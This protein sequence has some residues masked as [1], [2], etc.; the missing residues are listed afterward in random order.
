MRRMLDIYAGLGGASSAFVNDPSWEV[1]RLE[2]NPLITDPNSE[3]HVPGTTHADV[4]EWDYRQYPPGYFDLIWASPPCREFSDALAAPARLARIEG[5]EFYPDTSLL[6][7]AKEIIDY[8]QPRD[9]IIENVRGARKIFSEILDSQP[10]Q[11][12]GSFF[13][14]GYFPRLHLDIDWRHA[15]HHNDKSSNHPLR[16]NHRGKVPREIS[17]ALKEIVETQT[18]ITSW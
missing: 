4:M 5:R 16:A 6:L 1:I 13:L 18:R 3:H 11:I 14:W 10:R 2:N 8:Y 15:K 12:I 7:K 9:W 17:Q